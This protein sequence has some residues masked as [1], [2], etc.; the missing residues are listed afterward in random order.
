MCCSR[1]PG[2]GSLGAGQFFG[3][4]TEWR[5]MMLEVKQQTALIVARGL[6]A[7]YYQNSTSSTLN[8]QLQASGKLCCV[9]FEVF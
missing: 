3:G 8:V 4:F 9:V 1:V 6:Q 2:K 5:R 7:N